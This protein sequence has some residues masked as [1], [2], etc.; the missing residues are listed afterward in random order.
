MRAARCSHLLLALTL[1]AC[2]GATGGQ[3]D[4]SG[5]SGAATNGA[6]SSTSHAF[7][8][9]ARIETQSGDPTRNEIYMLLIANAGAPL[10]EGEHCESF[11]P[12][13]SIGPATFGD[14]YAIQ[15]AALEEQPVSLPIECV[16]EEDHYSCD[17]NFVAGSE[18]ESPWNCGIRF[19]MTKD[20][21]TPIPGSIMCTGTC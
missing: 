21:R 16:E 3:H 8:R 4:S 10:T 2:G 15:L 13:H 7:D 17:V 12:A 5:N 9:A 14:F 19:T 11:S 6:E 20:T 1:T 18:G